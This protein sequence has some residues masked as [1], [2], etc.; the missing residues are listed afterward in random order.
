M[1][2]FSD[3]RKIKIFSDVLKKGE[4]YISK[5]T[6]EAIKIDDNADNSDKYQTQFF[7]D[8]NNNNNLG[9]AA[10]NKKQLIKSN[11]SYSKLM[12][13]PDLSLPLSDILNI[14]NVDTFE[15]LFEL[16]KNLLFNN[17]SEYTIFRLV[18]TYTRI[19]YDDLKKTNK[20]LIK[21]FKLIFNNNATNHIDISLYIIDDTKLSSFIKKWLEKKDKDD[22]YFNIS[23]DVKN[24]LSNKYESI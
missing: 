5:H 10:N 13:I 4:T 3:V 8:N 18:D 14:Y 24:F 15:E 11:R 20:S 12:E 22:F 21:I 23:N 6:L 7:I 19:F 16:I 17:E 9:L 2:R 1:K